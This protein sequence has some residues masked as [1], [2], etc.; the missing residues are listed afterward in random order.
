MASSCKEARA[1]QLEQL[2]VKILHDADGEVSCGDLN[3][4]E[5]IFVIS[6]SN[7]CS[8]FGS[9]AIVTKALKV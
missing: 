9:D 2:S 4:L 6:D 7:D 1:T 8:V 3:K 5:S